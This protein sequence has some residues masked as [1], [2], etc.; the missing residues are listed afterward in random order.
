MT[1]KNTPWTR[2]QSMEGI[3]ACSLIILVINSHVIMLYAPSDTGHMT[4]A[5]AVERGSLVILL[6][7]VQAVGQA[8]QE[9]FHNHTIHV[10]P[11]FRHLG[12]GGFC[13]QQEQEPQT[14]R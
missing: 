4:R 9:G 8:G 12:G 10:S 11:A 1:G 13:E 14:P 5:G 7:D 3:G 2:C 6:G